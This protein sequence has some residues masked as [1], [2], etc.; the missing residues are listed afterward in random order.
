MVQVRGFLGLFALKIGRNPIPYPSSLR[1]GKIDFFSITAIKLAF[2]TV[3]CNL[4][5][6]PGKA[7]KTACSKGL[8]VTFYFVHLK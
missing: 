5:T 7:A 1:S 4:D 6:M 3:K 2:K 8:K